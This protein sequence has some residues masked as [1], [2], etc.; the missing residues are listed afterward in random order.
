MER[1]ECFRKMSEDPLDYFWWNENSERMAIDS[2]SVA[3]Q[4]ELIYVC[5][6]SFIIE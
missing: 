4:L 6:L 5:D 1:N 3:E 2:Q